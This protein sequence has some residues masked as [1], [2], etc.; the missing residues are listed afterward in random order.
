MQ[1]SYT[2]AI[3][4]SL[5]A[6]NTRA[7]LVESHDHVYG[8]ECGEAPELARRSFSCT[9]SGKGLANL[10]AVHAFYFITIFAEIKCAPT[11]CRRRSS[12]SRNQEF[13]PPYCICGWT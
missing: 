7:R 11:E 2:E 9:V 8:P 4:W 1:A 6:A 10:F 3:L 13:R 5:H 12:L